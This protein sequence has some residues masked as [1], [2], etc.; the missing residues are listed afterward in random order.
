M[1]MRTLLRVVGSTSLAVALMI[2]ALPVLA[3]IKML[4]PAMPHQ[5]R[6]LVR[7]RHQAAGR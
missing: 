7:L 6:G 3:Q 4:L 5:L 1:S 2:S